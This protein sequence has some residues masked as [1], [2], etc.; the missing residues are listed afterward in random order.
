MSGYLKPRFDK[1]DKDKIISFRIGASRGKDENTG[2]YLYEF[3]TVKTDSKRVA[4]R[5]LE[6]LQHE[7]SEGTLVK[8][9]GMTLGEYMEVW[10]NDYCKTNLAPRTIELYSY[11]NRV[12]ITPAIGKINLAALTPQQVQHLFSEKLKSGLA[13][14]TVQLCHVALHKALKNACRI[15]LVEN[16]MADLVDKP[17]AQRA[18]MK[19]M[20]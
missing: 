14:R 15:K 1:K 19:L 3:R 5:A 7:I 10:L 12:H 11:L 16:N 17:K 20:S 9:T 13:P 6:K 2:K 4:T 18:E 8:K